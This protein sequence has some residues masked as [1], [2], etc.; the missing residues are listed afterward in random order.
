MAPVLH[1]I[2]PRL[3]SEAGHCHQLVHSLAAAASECDI[4]IW[5]GRDAAD[6]CANWQGPGRVVPWFDRRWRRLQSLWL[7]RR[8]LREPGRVLI[9]T[10]GTADLQIAHWA[11]KGVIAP[12]KLFAFVHWL[13]RKAGKGRRLALIARRQPHIEI[14]APTTAVAD[15]FAACGYRS[16]AVPYPVDSAIDAS[17]LTSASAPSPASFTH[18]LVAGAAR[19]DK[20]FDHVAQFVFEMRRRGVV[21]P[22]VV[23]TSLEQRHRGD[24]VIEQHIER[25]RTARAPHVTLVDA[26]PTRAQYLA[27]FAGAIALQP[28]SAHD[29]EDRV[30]G[31]T[32]D[33]LSAGCPLVVTEGTWMA[34][35]V[36]RF[37]AGIVTADLSGAGLLD[38][39]QAVHVDYAR[40]AANALAAS[41]S[42]AQEHSARRLLDIVL[43]R[44]E[45]P[46]TSRAAP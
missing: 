21:L 26:T 43:Q 20:G 31:V 5:A 46:Q 22:T 13:G 27:Q 45:Q 35:M 19:M 6:I 25:L 37:D 36:R 44:G 8:L 17:A 29:F 14:L 23:Q 28:Y 30:S 39:V 9:S 42:L 11:A 15:F 4:T 12:H 40:Y 7:L 33:A 38:A 16:T 10:A 24:A 18:I 34:R 32:L 1:I 41:H 2:E 3:A